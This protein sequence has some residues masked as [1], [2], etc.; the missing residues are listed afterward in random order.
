MMTPQQI[1]DAAPEGATHYCNQPYVGYFYFYDQW[2]EWNELE[3][4]WNPLHFNPNKYREL[5]PL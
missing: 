4:C 3:D 2:F 5:K 1:K